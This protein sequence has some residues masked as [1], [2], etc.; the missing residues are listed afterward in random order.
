MVKSDRTD[1]GMSQKLENPMIKTIWL[2][3]GLV[4]T[5]TLLVA[6]CDTLGMG[7][8]HRASN[9]YAYLYSDQKGHIDTPTVPV[10]S[11]PL[12]VG[13]AFVPVDSSNERNAYS[14]PDDLTFSESQKMDLMKQISGQFKQYPFVKSI[15]LIPT[16]YLTP[17]GGFANLDQIR[18][19]Y[20]VDVMALL[21][22]DQ[23]QFTGEGVLSLTYWTIVGAYVVPGEKNDTKTMMDAAVYDIACRKLLFRAPGIGNVKGS[24]T[25]IN[26]SEQLRADSKK[27]FEQ[28]ATNLV[29]NLKVQLEAFKE[30]VTNAPTEY[31]IEYKPG[32]T[33][34]GAFGGMETIIVGGLGACFL[35]TRRSRQV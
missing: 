9:L 10:L 24:A 35:W 22:Y 30:Q 13:V 33:G 26:L 5:I 12:R 1:K 29:A 25:P 11:L 23:V 32:Y 15:E 3:I 17:R 16:A 6:G 28:A 8:H 20:G 19:M 31:K 18:T 14:L 21:S 34:G 4:A 27:G 2:T 7:Q